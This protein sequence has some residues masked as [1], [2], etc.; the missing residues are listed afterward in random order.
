MATFKFI[1]AGLLAVAPLA[2]GLEGRDCTGVN[3]IHPQC[4]NAD[5]V[6]YL[7]DFFYVGGRALDTAS[8]ELTA[9]KLYVEKL[10]PV[11]PLRETPIVFF[12]GGGC[13]GTSW[14]NTPDNRKGFASY[15]IEEGYVVYIV[16]AVGNG[17]ST[18][19]DL[20]GF[21]L[22]AGSSST[23]VEMGFSAPEFYNGYPQSQ[24][25]TQ[26]P[27]TGRAGDPTFENFKNSMVPYTTDNITFENAMRSSG[28]KLLN[29][30]GKSYVIGHSAGGSA[31]ILLSND[32]PELVAANI[33]LESST[34]PFFWYT[35]G[36][37]GF[38]NNAWGLA[39][40]PLNY[41]PPIS[42][43]SELK[44][45]EVGNSTTAKRSCFRQV[46]PARKLPNIASVPY[47]MITAEASVHV[48]YDHCIVE[49]MRQIGAK[50]EWIKLAERA[51]HGNGHF[52]HIEEN[53]GEIAKLVLD[54]IGDKENMI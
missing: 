21:P 20:E 34:I 31:G 50:P 28:C 30:I 40:T 22:T 42:D 17:R 5:A 43:P 13:S 27:G 18:N 51:I 16:D 2:S 11:F 12:H 46:E 8:G 38:F 54:W 25:H 33:N 36:T 7:R 47:L 49:Y 35:Y 45:V 14:L 4:R 26:F 15:F 41:T 6:P 1:C 10:R 3:A 19:M 52:M 37:A 53:N 44:R 29:L 9:D 32:C 24:M 39:N 48:T 23:L